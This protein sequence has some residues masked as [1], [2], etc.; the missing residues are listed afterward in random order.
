MVIKEK[1]LLSRSREF[2]KR[3]FFLFAAIFMLILSFFI[4]KEFVIALITAFVL[5]YLAK[6]L[7]RKLSKKINP[8][9]S[10]FVCLTIIVLAVLIPIFI[11]VF[12]LI[13]QINHSL[14]ISSTLKSNFEIIDNYFP[15]IKETL[16]N[17]TLSFLKSAIIEIPSIV[18][19]L[20]I[21]VM[22]TYY[23]ILDWENLIKKVELVI[24][25][26]D[27]KRIRREVSALTDNIVYGYIFIAIIEFIVAFIGFYLS[28]VSLFVILPTLIAILAFIPGLGPGAVW[29]PTL[30]YYFAVGDISTAIGVLITGILISAVI[31]TL[32]L[33]KVVGD[34]SKI[35]PFIFLLG[36]LG[37][38]PVFGIFGFII[39][40]LVLVYTQKIIEE[41]LK[42]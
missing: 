16:L 17:A 32:I 29:I 31:E 18:L 2:I 33:P 7:Q 22:G 25:F 5:A 8:K 10:A 12:S 9:L 28:G 6:P 36:V 35:H 15:N 4:I 37:G 38:V 20:F 41:S 39:G 42:E 40:P 1:D 24:P 23:L 34:K 13:S 26:Q 19:S 14:T 3:Y 11:L 27:K 21:I 30:I